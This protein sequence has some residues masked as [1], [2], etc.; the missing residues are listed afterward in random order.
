MTQLLILLILECLMSWQDNLSKMPRTL[1]VIPARLA[2]SRFPNKPLH[3]IMGIP[4][5]AHC[6]YRAQKAKMIDKLILATPDTEIFELG[7]RLGFECMMTSA[8]HERATERA[9]EVLES[10][11]TQK[12]HFENIILLQ[13]D[14]PELDPQVVDN[15]IAS[16]NTS[17]ASVINLVHAITDEGIQDVNV[18]K[19]IL[20]QN[21]TVNFFSR[22]SIPSNTAVS[23]RQLGMIGFTSEILKKFIILEP[24]K[25][26]IIESI[27]MM[28]LLDN[29][30]D[31]LAMEV[32]KSIIGV[33]QP[34]D[35]SLVEARLMHDPLFPEYRKYYENLNFK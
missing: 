25:H 35:I 14:E 20:T 29:D 26:E 8:K 11:E 1:G 33:D 12:K 24:S 16:M 4:M 17:K 3:P 34:K 15:L 9:A 19:A 22:A 7:E 23:F 32:T 18:V 30:I 2:S 13:G 31:I 5:I 27:D 6:L 10:L 21:N 28:R